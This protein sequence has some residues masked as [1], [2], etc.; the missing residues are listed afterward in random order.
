MKSETISG[1]QAACLMALFIAGSAMI[2]GNA[3]WVKQDSWM[4]LLLAGVLCLPFTLIYAR[5]SSL[6]PGIGFFDA[7]ADIFGRILGWIISFVMALYFFL[8]GVL[9]IRTFTEFTH[10]VTFRQTPQIFVG[11]CL[12]ILCAY[13]VSKGLSIMGRSAAVLFIAV[14]IIFLFST[15]M[16]IPGMDMDNLLPVA[17]QPYE[18]IASGTAAWFAFPLAESVALLPILGGVKKKGGRHALYIAALCLSVAL[19]LIALLRNLLVFGGD[20]VALMRFPSYISARII[21][22]G[23]FVQRIEAFIS[24]YMLICVFVRICVSL[25][26][27]GRGF[28]GLL[29]VADYRRLVF[30][31]ALLGAALAQLL[32]KDT[33][34]METWIRQSVWLLIPLQ[35][36][37]P[38]AIWLCAEV[39]VRRRSAARERTGLSG[40]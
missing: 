21:S 27:A 38:V 34:E 19:L 29:R 15:V 26:G 16:L 8:I 5:I 23:G 31:V 28:A 40:G 37:L 33:A 4:S 24:A 10:I 20:M 12:A 11:V 6:F 9:A 14:T 18:N 13:T 22:V 39:R 36:A 3:A 7:L 35:T 25:Y 2:T 32:F 1:R 30:P 17:A